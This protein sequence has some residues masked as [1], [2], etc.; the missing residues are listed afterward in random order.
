LEEGRRRF[1]D[2]P[3]LIAELGWLALDGKEFEQSERLFGELRERFPGRADGYIGGARVFLA[4]NDAKAA[5]QLYREGVAAVPRE[6]HIWLQYALVSMHHQ[7]RPIDWAEV[8]ARFEGLHT[9]F[10]SFDLGFLECVRAFR[11][12]GRLDEAEH[13]AHAALKQF[14]DNVLVA[15][16]YACV[17]RDREDWLGAERRYAVIADRFPETAAGVTGLAD[18]LMRSGRWSEANA[19]LSGALARLPDDRDLLMQ[20]AALATRS[21]N[22]VEALRRWEYAAERYP[23]DEQIKQ[24]LFGARQAG[25]SATTDEPFATG[26]TPDEDLARARELLLS[27]ESFGGTHMGCEFGLVQREFGVEPLGLLR[28]SNIAPDQLARALEAEFEGI[29]QPENTEFVITREPHREYTL[30]DRRFGL[31]MH[32]FISTDQVEYNRMLKQSLSRLQYLRQKLIDDLRL[33]EKIFVYRVPDRVLTRSEL[34]RIRDGMRAYGDNTLLYV[35]LADSTHPPGTV[36]HGE[37]PGLLIGYIDRFH[38]RP[39]GVFAAPNPAGWQAVCERAYERW[40]ADRGA[41][42]A[43]PR[44]QVA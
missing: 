10:P 19:L 29:G 20:H 6:P 31:A 25:A 3:N 9:Q 16:E 36:D 30:H 17:A 1:L 32:T 43:D 37:Q 15:V 2:N 38:V 4:A 39:D 11:R 24:G 26:G 28:W 12:F 7:M 5:E 23:Y 34:K 8:A 42:A 27:F 21:G 44:M 35:R 13:Y 33:G 41:V 40:S 22:W 14:P 18:V